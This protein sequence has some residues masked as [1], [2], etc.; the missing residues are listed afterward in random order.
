MS[1]ESFESVMSTLLD[2]FVHNVLTNQLRGPYDMIAAN[3]ERLRAAHKREIR[4]TAQQQY[5]RGYHAGQHS[6]DAEHR[7][8]AMRLRHLPLDG[9]SH[10]NLSQIARAI[11]HSDWGWTKGACASL[12][13]KLIDLMGG[14]SESTINLSEL[15]T[16]LNHGNAEKPSITEVGDELSEHLKTINLGD[17]YNH[18]L[19]TGDDAEPMTT[20]EL[21][22]YINQDTRR[23]K[24]D[25]TKVGDGDDTCNSQH[26]G[27]CAAGDGRD[28]GEQTEVEHERL[29]DDCG[30]DTG[31]SY[32]GLSIHMDG[33]NNDRTCPNDVPT[34]SI[35]DELREW[36]KIDVWS[37][38]WEEFEAIVDRID[39]RAK[40]DR[41]SDQLR[42]EKLV[43][44]R[45]AARSGQDVAEYH[46]LCDEL[47]DQRDD[48]M[49]KWL[50]EHA[51][52]DE[53]R[54]KLEF[55]RGGI[56]ILQFERDE[57][58]KQRAEM[59]AELARRLKERDELQ[60]ELRETKLEREDMAAKIAEDAN[61]HAAWQIEIQELRERL[62]GY[63][64]THV[65][66]PRDRNGEVF[67]VDGGARVN[68]LVL[69]VRQMTLTKSGWKI[70]AYDE[71]YEVE[72]EASFFDAC[73][74]KPDLIEETIEKLTLGEITQTEAVERIKALGQK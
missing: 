71:D 59:T 55:A 17:G 14:V 42:I 19:K 28:S 1:T 23:L 33:L 47:R 43:E 29:A 41:E 4:D 51:E 40:H 70:R 35:T 6:M 34:S 49:R 73:A 13:D 21:I 56:D 72:R 68:D 3:I 48:L 39:E 69:T 58:M 26:R 37:C 36:A 67:R 65:E 38:G 74:P 22:E 18:F 2:G 64:H 57:L 32:R 10:E 12:R 50:R 24:G 46:T 7:A 30:G 61:D 62:D 60:R 53:L 15:T 20:D 9:G 45:D 66:L 16:D 54:K 11:Y 8:V 25:A 31:G 52:C 5:S 44:Q 27:A 63:D